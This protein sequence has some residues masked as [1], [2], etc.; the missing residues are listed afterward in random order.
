MHFMWVPKADHQ[1]ADMRPSIGPSC[2]SSGTASIHIKKA[3]PYK[4]LVP[5]RWNSEEPKREPPG[6]SLQHGFHQLII[7]LRK[8]KLQSLSIMGRDN[9][10]ANIF[11]RGRT[12]SVRFGGYTTTLA[13]VAGGVSQGSGIGPTL[14]P[15]FFED[16][17]KS[18]CNPWYPFVNDVKAASA[19]LEED[20]ETT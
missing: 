4:S 16:L 15:I 6:P 10:G 2:H 3:L 14:F 7:Q 9:L 18:M 13:D 20:I 19:D 11:L 12:F 8:L 17:T 1:K 5:V